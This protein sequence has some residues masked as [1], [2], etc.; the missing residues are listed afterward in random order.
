MN[1]LENCTDCYP[2]TLSELPDTII[3]QGAFNIENQYY[4][5]FTDKFNNSLV[6]SAV[7]PDGDGIAI[8][9]VNPDTADPD[10]IIPSSFGSDLFPAWLNK[11]AGK[12]YIECSLT[13]DVWNPEAMT[14]DTVSYTCVV[15][16]FVF[17][18][19]TANVI[20]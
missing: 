12:F 19:S 8:I 14:F 17:N 5:K 15:A 20:A 2:V 6:T 1:L 7:T 10:N 4:F 3:I 18:D 13:I 16:E 11:N 9:Y